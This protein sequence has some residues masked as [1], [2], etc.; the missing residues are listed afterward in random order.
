[1]I[2]SQ[3]A[4]RVVIR[5]FHVR[6]GARGGATRLGCSLPARQQ[7]HTHPCH[8]LLAEGGVGEAAKKLKGWAWV[9]QDISTA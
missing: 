1:M 9:L 7:T 6:I 3:R 2:N 5:Y 8:F 4:E